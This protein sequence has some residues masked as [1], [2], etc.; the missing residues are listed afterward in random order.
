MYLFILGM[1]VGIMT[2]VSSNSFEF[3]YL[4]SLFLIK[5]ILESTNVLYINVRKLIYR[6][7]PSNL[8]YMIS[9]GEIQDHIKGREGYFL[10]NIIWLGMYYWWFF[11]ETFVP[12]YAK[13][14]VV[15]D[16]C[17][18]SAKTLFKGITWDRPFFTWI[19]LIGAMI[20]SLIINSNLR[21]DMIKWVGSP[22]HN[23]IEN[24]F[25][26]MFGW[27]LFQIALI[28]SYSFSREDI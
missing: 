23:F 9:M 1:K 6:L 2:S 21:F 18:F 8:R 17:G 20:I 24:V 3:W 11:T 26:R 19:F 4:G 14:Y 25:T 28:V 27:Y 13:K 16:D 15:I 10:E 12:G 7:F 5:R 22:H